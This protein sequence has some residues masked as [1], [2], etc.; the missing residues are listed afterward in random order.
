MGRR[1]SPTERKKRLKP[2]NDLYSTVECCLIADAIQFFLNR[3][4]PYLPRSCVEDVL[5]S[6]KAAPRDVHRLVA[7][8]P[9]LYLGEIKPHLKQVLTTMKHAGKKLFFVSNS[10]YWYVDAGMKHAF[11]PDWRDMWDII[12]VSAGK[13]N[14]YTDTARPFREVSVDSGRVEFTKVNKLEP[15]KV[16]TEGCVKELTRCAKWCMNNGRNNDGIIGDNDAT[17]NQKAEYDNENDVSISYTRNSPGVLYMGDSLFADMVDAKREFGW[18]TAAI[19]PELLHELEL[20]E[21]TTNR[22][23]RQSIDLLL[24][25]L[26]QVQIVLGN[27]EY[28]EADLTLLDE[29]EI[30]VSKWRDEQTKHYQNPF[31][32]VFRA[33]FQPSLFAHSLRRYCDLYVTSLEAFRNYSPQHRFYPEDSRLLGHEKW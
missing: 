8:N 23:S 9:K 3:K 30:Y 28:S 27:R 24:Q 26:R 32:S 12:I 10:P 16:Y 2:L 15:G 20:Q 18:T 6:I 29:L 19:V 1:L 21:N 4:I 11:G 17:A 33:R 22:L 25:S 13:P 7:D 5:D 31:G 14:F